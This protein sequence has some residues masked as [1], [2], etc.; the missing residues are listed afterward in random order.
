VVDNPSIIL[1]AEM[2]VTKWEV[3]EAKISSTQSNREQKDSSRILPSSPFTSNLKN[4]A[5]F[6]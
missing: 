3:V 1:G 2:A 4:S 6:S 5:S